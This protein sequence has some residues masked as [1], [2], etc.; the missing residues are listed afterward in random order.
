MTG[1][2]QTSTM[3]SIIK[4]QN[5]LPSGQAIFHEF[6]SKVT[7]KPSAFSV[8]FLLMWIATNKMV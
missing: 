6:P 2:N 1:N 4:F 3:H 5:C 7:A 8:L